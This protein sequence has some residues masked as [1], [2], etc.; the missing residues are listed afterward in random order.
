MN[1]LTAVHTDIG[2]KKKTNQ[3]AVLLR[4]A[5]TDYGKVVL[6]VICDGMGGLA[7]GEVA[8][9]TLIRVFSDWFEERLPELLMQGLTWER[10]QK[11][12]KEVIDQCNR[13]IIEYG[14]RNRVS[15][16]TTL[17]AVLLWEGRY[18]IV[19]IGDSRIYQICDTFLQLTRDQTYIQREMDLGNMTYEEAMRHPQRNVLLQCVGTSSSMM[20]VFHTGTYGGDTVFMLCSDG[21]R[22]VIT[23][24]EFYEYLNPCIL[25]NEDVMLEHARYLTE[26]NKYRQETDNISVALIRAC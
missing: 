25:K 6:G 15:L 20:P 10:V 7:R 19:N 16:G 4:I 3:D 18:H 13:K 1:Y 21:F 26:L 8:S 5:D 14:V 12:W 17:L 22:H 23:P 9:A 24:E 11:D 2:I